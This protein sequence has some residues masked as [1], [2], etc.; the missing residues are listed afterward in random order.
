MSL[1][2]TTTLYS[3]FE[4]AAQLQEYCDVQF[5]TI[6]KL[7]RENEAL[8]AE[9]SHLKDLLASTT[10]LLHPNDPVRMEVSD[11]QAIC[12]IQIEK[13]REKAFSRELTLEETKRLEILIKSLHSIREKGS[14]AVETSFTRL[15]PGATL[16]AL[17]L[18]AASPEP[19][20]E[21]D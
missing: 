12:E 20:P 19:Q 10:K 14:D 1:D 8:K 13:L 6:E 4:S 16:E 21:A 11:E 2:N 18:L 7:K 9:V 15:P 3:Q 17:T 5:K